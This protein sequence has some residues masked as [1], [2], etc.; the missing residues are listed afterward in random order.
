MKYTKFKNQQKKAC[1]NNLKDI[2]YQEIQ[3]IGV[4]KQLHSTGTLDPTFHK[5]TGKANPY[6]RFGY[7]QQKI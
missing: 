4:N 1:E 3:L 7:G 5:H 2:L 6:V